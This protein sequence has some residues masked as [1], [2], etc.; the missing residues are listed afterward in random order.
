MPEPHPANRDIIDLV[1]LAGSQWRF[2]PAGPVGLDWPALA[3]VA[4]SMGIETDEVF[5]RKLAIFERAALE[6]MKRDDD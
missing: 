2:G 6:A 1:I 5:Y 3:R 4:G